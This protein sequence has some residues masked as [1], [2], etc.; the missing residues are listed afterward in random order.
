MLKEKLD[1]LCIFRD[2]LRDPVIAALREYLA[3]P[4]RSAYAEFV[5]RL[6][7]ANG[8]DLGEYVGALCRDS[9]NIYVRTV[10]Q[11]RAVPG[12]MQEALQAEL[13]TLQTL[14]SLSRADLLAPLGDTGILLLLQMQ[15]TALC[16]NTWQ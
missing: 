15:K 11:G 12:Y 3:A 6:Y 14:A 4:S 16:L 13:D 2:L 1:T 5:S 8:G 9:E 7:S 10:G